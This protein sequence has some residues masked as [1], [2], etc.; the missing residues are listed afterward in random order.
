MDTGVAMDGHDGS[1]RGG[2]DGE[3][4]GDVLAVLG[5][6]ARPREEEPQPIAVVC[7]MPP[8]S[9]RCLRWYR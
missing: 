7:A 4:Q 9:E 6:E 2:Q 3:L 8:C 1:P 5:D